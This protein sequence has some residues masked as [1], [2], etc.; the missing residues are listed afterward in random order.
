MKKGQ[1]ILMAIIIGTGA[2]SAQLKPTSELE[3]TS[4]SIGVDIGRSFKMQGASI[5]ADLLAQGLKDALAG[6]PLAMSDSSMEA[7]VM[8]FQQ[9]LASRQ[10]ERSAMASS[11]NRKE[12]EAF[13]IENKTKPGIV[14]LP[15]GLQYRVITEGSGPKPKATDQVTVH[16]T[17]TLLNGRKFDSSY[18]QNSPVTFRLDKVIKGWT[19]GL[20][21]MS[22]GSKYELFIPSDLAYG[23]RQ[24]GPDIEPGATLVFTVE[25]LAIK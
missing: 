12:G 20:Q 16:Y 13:L 23:D 4:Y 19:E 25:L 21:L 2:A 11:E 15:S 5:S 14:A 24:M 8:G 22:V 17:G 6:G 18:D 9:A 1:W 3:R 7:C 10:E